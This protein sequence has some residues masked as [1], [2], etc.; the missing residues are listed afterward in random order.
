[1][2]G[3]ATTAATVNAPAFDGSFSQTNV[4][5]AGVDEGDIVKT[6]GN[7]L[8]MVSRNELVIMK[9]DP[10][11]FHIV[12]RTPVDGDAVSLYLDGDR[13]TVISNVYDSQVVINPL[14]KTPDG[15]DLVRSNSGKVRVAV[16]DVADRAAPHLVRET[17]ADG[18]Y[19]NSRAVGHFV[20]IAVQNYS[21]GLPAPASTVFNNQTIYETK[22]SSLARIAGHE[23]DLVLP[24]YWTRGTDGSLVQAGFVTDAAHLY[25][26][27]S[28]ND[29]NL[30]SLLSFD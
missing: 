22:E 12:S 21:A 13:V 11:D 29:Y 2:R 24:H 14:V 7:Y 1:P 15:F 8:Y 27:R 3:F 30:L 9:A 18:F 25:K 6:D 19:L 17:Y 5:V 23:L 20:Y 4:Q 26:P 16:Y 28:D 10:N